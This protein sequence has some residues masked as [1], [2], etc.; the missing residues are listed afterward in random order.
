[1]DH[2]R[3]A[4]YKPLPEISP[5]TKH[6]RYYRAKE[7]HKFYIKKFYDILPVENSLNVLDVGCG[8]GELL[9]VIKNEF[10]HWNLEGI[11][12][13][14]EFIDCAKS[15]EGLKGVSFDVR[16]IDD[17]SSRGKYDLVL[18]T[19]VL[20]IFS[21]IE[22]P[23]DKLIQTTSNNGLLFCDGLFNKYDVEVR[24]QYCDN[25]NEQAEGLWRTDWNQHS[26]KTVSAYLS[27]RK[28][29]KSYSFFE[30]EMDADLSHNSEIHVQQFTFRTAGGNNL[31]TN[32]TNLLLNK[33]LL[34]INL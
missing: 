30:M 22:K 21:D 20:Q 28:E 33:T 15:F 11:D 12:P 5:Y 4:K 17:L 6:E 16:G 25:S 13:T 32:G 2:K 18:C 19:G 31:I 23:I 14:K 10:P 24:M 34:V 26:K 29:I 8:N 9:F 1:M 27:T 3:D 7:T